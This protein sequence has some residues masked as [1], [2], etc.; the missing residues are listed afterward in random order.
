MISPGPEGLRTRGFGQVGCV[1]TAQGLEYDFAGVILGEDLVARGGRLI[2]ER[3]PNVDPNLKESTDDELDRIIRNIY[4]VLPTR[5][6]KGAV[7]Y[8]C[9]DRTQSFLRALIPQ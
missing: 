8:S 9:D 2:T 4:K 5:G 3:E 7:I 1:Y 6:L